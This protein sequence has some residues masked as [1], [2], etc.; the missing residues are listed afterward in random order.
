MANILEPEWTGEELGPPWLLR[1]A[2][3]GVQAGAE[4]LGATL[5][6]IAPG[7]RVSPLHAHHANEELIVVLSGTPTLQTPEGSRELV[8]GGVVAVSPGDAALIA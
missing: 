5:Y 6:E 7:G 3:L 8:A 4:Q 2:S 1:E